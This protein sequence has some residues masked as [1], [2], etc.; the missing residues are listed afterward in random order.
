MGRLHRPAV[1]YGSQT[2]LNLQLSLRGADLW[3][4]SNLPDYKNIPGTCVSAGNFLHKL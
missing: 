4:R 1:A 3:R 2:A